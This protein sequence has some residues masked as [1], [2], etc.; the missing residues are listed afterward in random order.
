MENEKSIAELINSL[1][2]SI[3]DIRQHP[4]NT[5]RIPSNFEIIVRGISDSSGLDFLFSSKL[6]GII[7]GLFQKIQSGDF[8]QIIKSE[9]TVTIIMDTEEW[10][11]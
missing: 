3:E 9:K 6:D 2:D 8:E 10:S 1:S 4:T 5:T 7:N 11:K